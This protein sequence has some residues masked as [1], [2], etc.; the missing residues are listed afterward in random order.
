M[1][2]VMKRVPGVEILLFKMHLV[3]IKLVQLVVVS[4]GKS[5]LFPLTVTLM[6]CILVLWGQMLATSCEY[7][8]VHPEGIVEQGM[9]NTV[10]VPVS[11]LVPTPWRVV[12]GRLPGLF[13]RC[14]CR[15]QASSENIK[16]T[17]QCPC[18]S[19]CWHGLCRSAQ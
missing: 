4:P 13:Y 11:I 9:K 1:S 10:F 7:V 6:R 18:Q 2:R 16:E 8:T 14:P 12:Q 5:N 17:G 19:R 3:L 15:G